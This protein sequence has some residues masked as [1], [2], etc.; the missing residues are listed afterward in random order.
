MFQ[1]F[2]LPAM[3]EVRDSSSGVTPCIVMKNDG[4]LNHQCCIF[5]SALGDYDLFAKLKEPLR[6]TRYKIRDELI[7]AIGQSLRNINKDGRVDG[8]RRL[9]NIW[10]GNDK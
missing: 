8:V 10:Q 5:S 9:P 4:V 7:R 3:H 6:G 1:N 2:P